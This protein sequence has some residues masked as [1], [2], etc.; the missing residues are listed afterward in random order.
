MSG[1]EPAWLT[2][3]ADQ[4]VALMKEAIGDLLQPGMDMI[5]TMLTEPDDDASVGDYDKWDRT[6]D[7][8]GTYVPPKVAGFFTGQVMREINSVPVMVHFG[9]CKRCSEM[10]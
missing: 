4:R 7:N 10:T 5:F 8:C 9:C 1:Q 2:A 3:K 6:C